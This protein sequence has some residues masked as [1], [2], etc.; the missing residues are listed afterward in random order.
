MYGPQGLGFIVIDCEKVK[1]IDP[2]IFGTQFEGIRGGTENVPAI[3][4][5]DVAMRETFRNRKEKN[6]KL[7]TMKSYIM[8]KLL[9]IFPTV[10]MTDFRERP[11]DM[12]I[13]FN[14]PIAIVPM[15]QDNETVANTLTL[16]FVKC[17]VPIK[18]KFCN[19]ILRKDLLDK[20]IIVSIGS[21]CN[22]SSDEPSHVLKALKMPYPVRAGI[23]RIS[24]NDTNTWQEVYYLT[25][26]LIE[27]VLRQSKKL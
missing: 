8:N 13:P 15:S 10:P 2:Q 25:D 5:A 24:L 9:K 1:S 23:I 11:D 16:S 21:A 17:G 22:T 12:I 20:K 26:N 4:S 19:I 6:Q 27:A 3:A 18:Q 14:V 7:A